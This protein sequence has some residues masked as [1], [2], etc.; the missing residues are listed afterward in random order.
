MR[1]STAIRDL[2]A[3]DGRDPADI[4]DGDCEWF[5]SL[6]ESK[7]VG[8]RMLSDGLILRGEAA[9]DHYFVEFAG[10]FY[11]AESPDG[12]ADWGSLPFYVRERQRRWTIYQR[13]TAHGEPCDVP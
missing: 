13:L 5:A 10:R 9:G 3:A 2:V 12:V 4:N 6:I 7:V 1:I 11:D 8:A